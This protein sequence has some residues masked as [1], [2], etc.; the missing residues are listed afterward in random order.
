M[1]G[2]WAVERR[3]F[4]K[5]AFFLSFQG[6]SVESIGCFKFVGY[7]GGMKYVGLILNEYGLCEKGTF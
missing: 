5:R 1:T 4:G 3:W 7:F 6:A 2:E